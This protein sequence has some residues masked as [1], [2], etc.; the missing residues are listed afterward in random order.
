MSLFLS[1]NT[2]RGGYYAA[3][4]NPKK[5]EMSIEFGSMVINHV[6]TV[7]VPL[8]RGWSS[9]GDTAEL[10]QKSQ[11]RIRMNVFYIKKIEKLSQFLS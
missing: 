2:I 8:K 3:V 7:D 9:W 5:W 10:P 11:E 4:P 1:L 6:P